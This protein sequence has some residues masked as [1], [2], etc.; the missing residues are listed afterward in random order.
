MARLTIDQIMQMA[1]M[2][3]ERQAQNAGIFLTDSGEWARDSGEGG[4]QVLQ[5]VQLEDLWGG[6]GGPMGALRDQ[7][8]LGISDVI[9]PDTVNWFNQNKGTNFGGVNDYLNYIYG[10]GEQ[11]GDYW[12]LPEGQ[13][14]DQ[15]ANT[16]LRYE[17]PPSFGDRFVLPAL[18]G[19]AGAG[20][21]GMLPGTTN[22]FGGAGGAAGAGADA[23]WGVNPATTGTAGEFSLAGGTAGNLAGSGGLSSAAGG[24]TGLTAGGGGLGLTVPASATAMGSGALLTPALA[25]AAGIPTA[26]AGLGAGSA[27]S[28]AQAM[29]GTGGAA[30]TTAA[31]GSALGRIL[32]GNPTD[33][34][35]AQLLGAGGSSLLGVLGSN[36]QADAYGDVASQYLGLGA[37]FRE[38]LLQSYAPGFSMADQPDFQN[39]MDVGAQA[40]ARATSARV[41]N[42]VDNPGAY[43][44]MQKYITGSL[45]LPQLNT[46]RSQLGSFGQLGTNT[47]GT[48]S[49]GEA[50]QAGGVYDAI[51]AGLAGLTQPKSPY[52]DLLKGILGNQS[53]GFNLNTGFSL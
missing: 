41:G 9:S 27:L 21:T 53:G 13:S 39:A 46:Y 5:E 30:T 49:M 40:A 50:S 52:E 7:G 42:P 26:S 23:A 45:A 25:A 8:V 28:A 4:Y 15:Y 34:D 1:Q 16:P 47:A 11:V 10:G 31:G 6:Q 19:V 14:Y 48:A 43:A 51:G 2:P 32:S 3:S 12:V 33:D 38:K 44:E 29:G 18:L 20:L 17:A 36:A 35:W 37:P 24:V 22:V